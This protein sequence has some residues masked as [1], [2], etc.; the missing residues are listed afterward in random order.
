[1][2]ITRARRTRRL[3]I[4]V[5]ALAAAILA[6]AAISGAGRG[7]APPAIRP[8]ATLNQVNSPSVQS[9]AFSPDGTKLATGNGDGPST[10]DLWDTAPRHLIRTLADPDD[11]TVESVAFS[12][13]GT[14]LAVGD[15]GGN[16]YL[17]DAATGRPITAFTDPGTN[18]Q[19]AAVAFSPD[20]GLLAVGDNG[21]T[22][23]WDISVRHR[24]A[25]LAATL[26]DPGGDGVNALAFSPDGRLLAAGGNLS[27]TYLWDVATRH[28]IA[29]VTDPGA[30]AQVSSV[31][32]SPNSTTLATGD[33]WTGSTYL[34]N[35]FTWRLVRAV[36][37]PGGNQDGG[38]VHAVAFN[39]HGTLATGDADQSAYLWNPSTGR[40][41]ATLSDPDSSGIDSVAFSPAGRLLATGD[42]NGNVYLWHTG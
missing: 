12:P 40:L 25:T 29:T 19:V 8:A 14:T 30:N 1:M 5:A 3:L 23:L 15:L 31:A 22:Y 18:P 27:R 7:T 21:R 4:G 42:A 26:A 39:R 36:A 38:G 17:W 35:T 2:A 10:V 34:W 32:F 9:L 20:G 24:T 6:V 37:D 11:S 41:I 28:L 16:V 33:S 13:D